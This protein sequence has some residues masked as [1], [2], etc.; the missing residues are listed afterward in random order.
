MSVKHSAWF[1]VQVQKML[2]IIFSVT[3]IYY[4]SVHI[5]IYPQTQFFY[6]MHI[7]RMMATVRQNCEG[8]DPPSALPVSLIKCILYFSLQKSSAL[9]LIFPFLLRPPFK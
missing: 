4:V 9:P 2:A 8:T 5:H 6:R 3:I 7:Q 1:M